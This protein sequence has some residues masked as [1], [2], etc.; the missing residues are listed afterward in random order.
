MKNI[1]S[2]KKIISIVLILITVSLSGQ[3]RIAVIQDSQVR[4]LDTENGDIIDPSFIS[5]DSGTPK[6]LIQ[7]AEEIWVGYQLADKIDRFDLD[8]NFLSSIDTG[9][10]NIR[11]LS[12]V[13]G[14]EVWVCN[15]GTNNG[16]PGDAII[17]FDFDGN[18]LGF[19]PTTPQSDS[20]FDI[21]DT[22]AG[23]VYISYSGTNNIERRDY[24][25]AFLGN[26]VD[27]GVVNFIQQIEIEEPG[28]IL[29]AVFSIISGGNQN[30]LYR[31]SE[32]DGSIIDYWSLGNLRGV[33]KLGNGDI[34]WSSGAGISKLNPATGVSVLISGGSAQYF[35][36]FNLDGCVTPAT[37]T[38]DPM[39]TFVQGATLADI[40]VDPIDVTW[41]ATEADAMNNTNP[42]PL[43]TLLEDGETYYAV[44]IVDGCLS[45]PFAV[46]VTV[47]LS[48]NEFS[49]ANFSYYPNPTK[50]KLTLKHSSEISEISISNLLGQ[51]ILVLHPQNSEV[52]LNL[53]FL[54]KGIYLITLSA[55]EAKK[56][57]NIIKE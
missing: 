50:D 5:L 38:G 29:A 21:I 16:A 8:G 42:L 51:N 41:F 23:E 26:I 14:I 49:E 4:L 35:G 25:G 45:E 18:N 33:A 37:P 55:N 1:T 32:T 27:Q 24:S 7:V 17:R 40:V 52:E 53:T 56:T 15:S 48:I 31:F 39:Q 6:A 11:G 46:T 22:G 9:L 43:N 3:E 30:G 54:P 10:D 28:V 47:T 12:I 20:P 44:N 13:N 36:R 19:F 2:F 57:I 34:L